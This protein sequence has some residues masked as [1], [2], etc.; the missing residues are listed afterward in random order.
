LG[1]ISYRKLER[2]EIERFREIDRSEIVEEVYHYSDGKLEL[3][4]EYYD[5]RGFKPSDLEE[6]ISRLYTLWDEDGLLFGGFAEAKIVGIAAL[7]NKFRGSRQEYLKLELLHVSQ[8]YRKHGVGRKLVEL[9]KAE[10]VRKGATKLY[11]S[12]TPSKN[13]VNFYMGLGCQL[14]TE[15][16]RELFE[17]EPEDIH[18]ELTISD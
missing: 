14:T 17:L 11:I 15:I 9:A 6:I 8:A 7:E 13:T 18:L 10:A 16:D 5:I 4:K 2:A 1:E 12:A 3:V